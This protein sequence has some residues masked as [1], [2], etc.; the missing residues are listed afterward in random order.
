MAEYKTAEQYVVEKCED[1]ERKLEAAKIEHKFEL[2]KVQ[3]ELEKTRAELCEVYDAINPLRDKIEMD[4][5]ATF[6]PY[7]RFTSLYKQDNPEEYKALADLFGIIIPE[8][9]GEDYA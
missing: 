6:G 5:S 3:K 2:A 7:M 9:E 4:S 8:E 1:L